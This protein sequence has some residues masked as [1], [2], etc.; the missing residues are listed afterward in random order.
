[1]LRAIA[2]P[3]RRSF[4]RAVLLDLM[5]R[6]AGSLLQG[7]MSSQPASRASSDDDRDLRGNSFF[8]PPV[9]PV[10]LRPYRV[11]GQDTPYV[12]P[13]GHALS[14]RALQDVRSDR[15]PQVALSSRF[16]LLCDVEPYDPWFSACIWQRSAR[17]SMCAKVRQHCVQWHRARRACSM[18]S[19]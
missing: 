18:F 15:T 19:S 7:S 6:C 8:D 16:N 9:C 2:R 13:C 17:A 10:T 4:V 12:L 11:Y 14:Q 5:R 3:Q 1:M